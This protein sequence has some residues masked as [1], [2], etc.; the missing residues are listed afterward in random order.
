MTGSV[1][2]AFDRPE[3]SNFYR[4]AAEITGQLKP[5]EPLYLFCPAV[6]KARAARFLQQF[7]GTVSYAVK[8]NPEQR[9]LETLAETGLQHYDVASLDEVRRVSQ[10]CPGAT[11]HF[12]NPVK[13][14]EAIAEAYLRYGVRSF[15]LDEMS[16]LE[17]IRRC[18][19]GDPAVVYT[20]RFKLDHASAAYDFGSKF[21]AD[22]AT[23]TALLRAVKA[24]GAAAAITFHPGS[25]CTDPGMYER[26]LQAAADITARA[27]VELE[28]VNVG[29]GFPE[30]YAGTNLPPLED[31]F[32]TITRARDQYFPDSVK[33]VC[34]PGRGIVASCISLLA[35]IIHVRNCGETLFVND[36]VY[37]GMQEQSLVDITL[38]A[39]VWREGEL[40]AAPDTHYHVFGPTCDP[41]DRL[42]RTTPL[43]R[44]VKPGDYIEFGLLGAYGS[45][46]TT[47]FNGFNSST[48]VNVLEATPFSAS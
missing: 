20:V 31:Y 26:Y 16:E 17:K 28:F 1:A 13:A 24:L 2:T 3:T 11:L 7:P 42:S 8:A 34:E 36:G 29:G 19:G 23:A 6:L 25:Q 33:L 30:H 47:N 9:V 18:T 22:T 41:V 21:G 39:R 5:T 27:G 32:E 38:P 45:A 46:T 10:Y 14:E 4:H 15:A 35:R 40:L 43:P 12:N 48:Y 37:G 44:G